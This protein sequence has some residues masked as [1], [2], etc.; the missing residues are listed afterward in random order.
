[1]IT[2][3]TIVACILAL[4]PAALFLR[5]LALYRPLPAA[6][7]TKR[8]CSVL[9]PARNEEAN[10]GAALDSVLASAGIEFEVIVLDDGSTDRTAEIVRDF[11]AR[12]P[13]VRLETAQPLPPGWCGKN[14]ACHQLAALATQPL[15]VFMD[16]DVRITQPG[17]LSRLAH[18]MEKSGAALA[19]GVPHEET[20]TLLER[21][22]IPLIH[23]VLLGFL[24]IE[25]MRKTTDP[26]FAAACG[27]ILAVRRDAY[28]HSGGHASIPDRI[29]DAV[30]LTRHFRA[31]GFHTDLF[32]ATDTFRCRM[33]RRA[34]EVWHG[35]AK[36][37]HEGL[38]TPQLI[39]PSTLLLLGGQVLPPAL[40]LVSP[41]P[42]AFVAAAAAFAPRLIGVA[43]FRQSLLGAILHPL[44]ICVL[45]AIQWFAFFRAIRRHPATWK[46]RSYAPAAAT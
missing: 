23:F 39:I 9:I 37:A 15:L 33:Y 11:A 45:V 14:F 8:R 46:G 13:R 5:N 44:G 12:D 40:V 24:P 18:F 21:L 41:S 7:A 10:I 32:D 17:A 31:H 25:R 38:A 2:T 26:R 30:A 6:D 16:A 42:L 3:L 36:N 4:I 19:S 27:Q 22:I 28:E 34:G 29:H 35:F 20:H 1:M 43:H